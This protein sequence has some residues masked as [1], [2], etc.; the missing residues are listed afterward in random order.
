MKEFLNI[1]LGIVMFLFLITIHE[2][3]HFL[4]AKLSGIKVNEF[5]VGM[6]PKIWGKQG[7]E[8]LYSF[9]ALPIGGYVMMEGE[10]TDSEDARSY[11]NSKPW[12]RFLT[13]LAGPATNLIFAVLIFLIINL[14]TGVVSNKIESFSENSPA[15]Q[16]GMQIGDEIKSV[17]GSKIRIFPEIG[18]NLNKSKDKNKVEVVVKRAQKELKFD[19]VP[20]EMEGR[21]VIGITPLVEKGFLPSLGNAFNLTIFIMVQI[22]TSL[23]GLFSGVLGLEQLGGPVAVIGQVSTV[24]SMGFDKFLF[25]AAMI[26]VNLGFFNLIPIP[27]LDGSKLLFITIEMITGKPINRKF[28][29]IISI[30]GFLFL[31][32]LMI[33]VTIK[34]VIKLF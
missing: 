10:E 4:G 5:A 30:I 15:Q 13:I 27:A 26:S 3:G 34:D 12:K 14:S 22:W 19:I 6:G 33:I 9:R 20:Q 11:N 16:A 31:I 1:G 18:D 32:G 29:Q 21:K 23:I 28:E 24:A 17:N 25:F 2:G 8:T 7:G